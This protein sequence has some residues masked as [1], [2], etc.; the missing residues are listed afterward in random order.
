[1]GMVPI[2]VISPLT[3]ARSDE[4]VLEPPLPIARVDNSTGG[5]GGDADESYSP[6]EQEPSPSPIS[7]DAE[8]QTTVAD[9]HPTHHISYF[10]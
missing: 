6:R 8:A 2:P 4:P 9:S 10:A 5:T 7:S 3:V 1:M